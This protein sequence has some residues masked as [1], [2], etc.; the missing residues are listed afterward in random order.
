SFARPLMGAPFGAS[1][2]KSGPPPASPDMG[3]RGRGRRYSTKAPLGDA[4]QQ[5]GV[6]PAV[7]PASAQSVALTTLQAVVVQSP[8][9]TQGLAASLVHA[10]ATHVSVVATR[11][12]TAPAFPHV[13]RAA[14]G[15]RSLAHFRLRP[16]PRAASRSAWATQRTYRPWFFHAVTPPA[17]SSSPSHGHAAVTAIS[18]ASTIAASH[19]PPCFPPPD[20]P[21]PRAL[22]PPSSLPGTLADPSPRP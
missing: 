22:E 8:S 18:R 5:L 3:R 15:R 19:A 11:H 4:V 21:G 20:S 2:S 14:H 7:P 1:S 13:E 12:V 6:L 16:A 17:P 9:T 10:P